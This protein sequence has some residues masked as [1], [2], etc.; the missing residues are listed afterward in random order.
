VNAEKSED[1]LFALTIAADTVFLKLTVRLKKFSFT[2][3]TLQTILISDN[4]E[5]ETK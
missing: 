5:R 3:M 4:F 2:Q 1:Q